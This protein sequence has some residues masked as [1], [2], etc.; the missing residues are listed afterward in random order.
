MF[1]FVKMS[2][3]SRS[4][5]GLCV[6]YGVLRTGVAVRQTQQYGKWHP[7]PQL[8]LISHLPSFTL[9]CHHL[10]QVLIYFSARFFLLYKY[11]SVLVVLGSQ[12]VP[13][14]GPGQR[15]IHENNKTRGDKI[16]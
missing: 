9:H 2:F 1:N 3:R 6:E 14:F 16:Y 13:L 4:E 11:Y 10:R 15:I 8:S 5:C 7:A 12:L